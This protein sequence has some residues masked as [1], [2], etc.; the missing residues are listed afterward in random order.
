MSLLAPCLRVH[1]KL[2]RQNHFWIC[3]ASR[4]LYITARYQTSGKQKLRGVEA[5]AAGRKSSRR[6]QLFTMNPALL[7]L[8]L[9]LL[10]TVAPQSRDHHD[11]DWVNAYRQ[12]FNFQCPHGEALVAIR[13]YFS[14]AE[15]SDRLWSFEC[16]PTPEGLGEPSDC[17][18]DDIN[19]AGLEWWV[20]SFICFSF[21]TSS[22]VSW[23]K[24][25]DNRC[26]Q[27][28]KVLVSMCLERNGWIS[29]FFY[30]AVVAT[31]SECA[32]FEHLKPLPCWL[33]G[34]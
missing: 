24:T 5:E 33:S 27:K 29:Y 19:R 16:Q 14:E 31:F 23:D 9:S 1:L 18:W 32:Y 34:S 3:V 4:K 15:G 13:S 12:G 6:S 21:F 11:M 30:L 25:A 8:V 22:P 17:W 7:A 26:S 20:F 2:W 10:A 28:R